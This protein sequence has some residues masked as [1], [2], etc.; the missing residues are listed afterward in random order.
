MKIRNTYKNVTG[1]RD[2]V[3][4]IVSYAIQR[5]PLSEPAKIWHDWRQTRFVGHDYRRNSSRPTGINVISVLFVVSETGLDK[6]VF[7]S[8]NVFSFVVPVTGVRLNVRSYCFRRDFVND[9]VRY[10][11]YV[12]RTRLCSAVRYW[13]PSYSLPNDTRKLGSDRLFVIVIVVVETYDVLPI[14]S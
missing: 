5:I 6:Y 7:N 10:P 2:V 1:G 12:R 13:F 3:Y 9:V 4:V 8:P 11:I 14:T